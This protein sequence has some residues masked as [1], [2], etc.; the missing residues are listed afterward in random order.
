ML[1]SYADLSF[2]GH[3]VKQQ[4]PKTHKT[5]L[6]LVVDL[7]GTL[8][9]SDML[10]ETF[11]SVLSQNWQNAIRCIAA[12]PFGRLELK[13]IL[14]N[15]AC[16][17]VTS[18][19]YD[20]SVLDL[21][22]D[23]RRAGGKTALVS[24]SE[25]GLVHSISEHLGLFD[26]AYGSHGETNL[27]GVAKRGFLERHYGKGAF[28]YAGDSAA[29]LEVWKSADKIVT[30]NAS[31]SVR[32]RAEQIGR[33]IQHLTK[34][35]FSISSHLNALR[36]HQWVKN[37]LI[38]LPIF[39]SH[40][41]D[42]ASITNGLVAFIGFCLIASAVYVLNDLLDLKSDRAHPSKC[43][44]PLASGAL[45]LA[46]G[47]LMVPTIILAGLAVSSVV[48][49]LFTLVI[50]LYFGLTCTYSL[51]LKRLIG[52][53]ICTLAILYTMR[54]VAEVSQPTHPYPHGFLLFRC[55]SFSLAALKRQGELV[56]MSR[57]NQLVA[58]GWLEA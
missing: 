8:I 24:A 57:R 42:S 7:D 52:I 48:G 2:W 50:V 12:L 34:P 33:P 23:H 37:I 29:D 32:A 16:I 28:I 51:R 10:Y 13:K 39:A 54:V 14:S 31:R 11:W 45:S 47:T 21:I 30:V 38:F 36:P 58:S 49:G 20:N 25:Q 22:R 43:K 5:P 18:L 40:K 3:L 26:E 1:F 6:V 17:D 4:E 19:P 46:T 44:R 41:F 27:K 55:S 15:Q 53:D 56:D 9:K 35:S